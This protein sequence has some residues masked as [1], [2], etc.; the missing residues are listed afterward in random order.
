MR[1]S[2]QS[3]TV[4]MTLRFEIF[5]VDLDRAVDFYTRVLGFALARDERRG[6]APYVELRRDGVQV[7]AAAR[8]PVSSPECR[9]PP[10]GVELVL[11]VDDV[12]AERDAVRRA[13]WV[14]DE[15]LV[16]RPW[17]LTDFRVVDPDGYLLR[18]T[19]R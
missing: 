8:P 13:G 9:R 15:D 12:A 4:P 6:P 11:E 14:L 2:W 1:P 18:V 3:G 10:T 7:G 17:G 5:P 16:D 19:S